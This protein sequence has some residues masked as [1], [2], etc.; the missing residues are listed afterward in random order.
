MSQGNVEKA[1]TAEELF[2]RLN[3][4]FNARDLDGLERVSHPTEFEFTS[5]FVS[6]EGKP[7]RDWRVYFR[8][9]DASW[10]D[11]RIQIDQ[12]ITNDEESIAAIALTCRG[13]GKVSGAPVEQVVYQT[14]ELR[15]G[16]VGRGRSCASLAEAIEAAGLAG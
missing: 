1:A 9:I 6:I 5:H 12:V 16:R 11:F 14:W 7:Y 4:A 3:E 2:G 8:D 13:F 10:D 15:D